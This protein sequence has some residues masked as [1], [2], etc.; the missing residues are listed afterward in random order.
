MNDGD[1]CWP[2][3]IES[4]C[5]FCY[6][7]HA[8]VLGRHPSGMGSVG[9]VA[10]SCPYLPAA[11]WFWHVVCLSRGHGIKI[12]WWLAKVRKR[13]CHMT[14]TWTNWW[15]VNAPSDAHPI[16]LLHS[17]DAS[18]PKTHQH[19]RRQPIFSPEARWRTPLWIQVH[20]LWSKRLFSLS[21]F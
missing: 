2:I 19:R 5:I 20:S 3:Y 6:L 7:Y 1:V 13:A 10:S 11:Q 17:R 15:R 18:I 14:K 8:G 16:W 9:E 4:T 21:N 12:F